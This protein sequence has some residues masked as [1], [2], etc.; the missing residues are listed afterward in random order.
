M[1]NFYAVDRISRIE[2]LISLLVITDNPNDFATQCEVY[3]IVGID[4]DTFTIDEIAFYSLKF[5]GS[6][7]NSLVK[8][9]LSRQ[10]SLTFTN[11]SRYTLHPKNLSKSSLAFLP[12]SFNAKPFL[13]IKM[14]L[15]ACFSQIIS[16]T[17][18]QTSLF[19]L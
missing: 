17:I 10:F 13:P 3:E 16:A 7:P 6:N 18:S 5:L 19:S 4:S 14:P 15:C 12:V 11:N 2:R 8:N 1:Y 9:S